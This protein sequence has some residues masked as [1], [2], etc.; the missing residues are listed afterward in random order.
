MGQEVRSWLVG[1]RGSWT[2]FD[3]GSASDAV[4]VTSPGSTVAYMMDPERAREW[5]AMLLRMGDR[6]A[7]EA[8]MSILGEEA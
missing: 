5:W 3:L 8:D 6:P 7:D 2:R 1:R 4:Y